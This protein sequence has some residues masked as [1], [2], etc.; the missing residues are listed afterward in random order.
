MNEILERIKG[1]VK[2]YNSNLYNELAEDFEKCE[3]DLERLELL[4]LENS[5]LKHVIG[6]LELEVYKLRNK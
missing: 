4:K 6:D 5:I 2:L 1:I 3:K